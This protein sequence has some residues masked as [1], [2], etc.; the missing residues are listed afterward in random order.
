MG[1]GV[2]VCFF[3]VVGFFEVC[4]LCGELVGYCLCGLL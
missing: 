1:F 4:V 3:V 2:E